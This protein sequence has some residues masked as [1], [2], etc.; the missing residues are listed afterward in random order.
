[1]HPREQDGL[2][3]ALL[4]PSEKIRPGFSFFPPLLKP[5][6]SDPEIGPQYVPPVFLSV[7][8]G[9]GFIKLDSVNF[10]QWVIQN[11]YLIAETML[12]T[13]FFFKFSIKKKMTF[14]KILA[15]E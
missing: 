2:P 10:L 7:L 6:Q 4:E 11:I 9:Y 1:M 5:Q 8:E 15:R 14:E 13:T 12:G 3:A